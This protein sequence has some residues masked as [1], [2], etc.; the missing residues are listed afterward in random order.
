MKNILTVMRKEFARFFYDKRMIAGVILPAIMIYV[1]YSFMGTALATAFSPDDDEALVLYSV[2]M[3]ASILNITQAD[4]LEFSD[5]SPQMVDY[6]KDQITSQ[7]V[8]LLMIFPLNFDEDVAEFDLATAGGAPAP[9]IEIYFNSVD[10]TSMGIYSRIVTL[11]DMYE[12]SLINKF[13]INRDVLQADLSTTEDRTATMVASLMPMLLMI[14][15][16]S[17]CMGLALESIT[18]EKERGTLAT[19]LVSPLKRRELAIGKILSLAVLSFISGAVTAIAT[20]LA[21]PNLMGAGGDDI[22][23]VSIYGVTDYI[24][25]SFI[26]LSTLLLLVA[27]ISIVSAF[28][29]TVKE[30][31]SYAMP[32]MIVVMLVGVSGMFGGG[33]QEEVI[34]YIIPL[35]G[36]VQSMIGVFSRNYSVIN[37]IVSCLSTILYAAIGGFVLTKMFNSEKI[38]FGL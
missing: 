15:L 11:L 8:H 19:L 12:A 2:N 32:L 27:L 38:M 28:A 36:N 22:D 26:I 35:Y 9:N 25:L 23:A 31:G 18:G 6:I 30:A 24:L 5:V 29:K 13:D 3:P 17:S 1:V 10:P 16:Y 33:A 21:I 20:I 37:I 4:G 7:D 34:Y 14:F